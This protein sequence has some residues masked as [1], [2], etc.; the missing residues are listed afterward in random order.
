MC[1]T[2]SGCCKLV[3]CG[4]LMYFRLLDGALVVAGLAVTCAQ[5]QAYTF[6]IDDTAGDA[7]IYWGANAHNPR[8]GDVISG[9]SDGH[10]TAL[11]EIKGLDAALV[12]NDLVFKVYTNYN[13]AS[14]AGT[15]YGDLFMTSGAN[16]SPAP[17]IGVVGAAQ[18]HSVLD[19]LG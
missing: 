16:Y 7:D 5:A 18:G 1:L 15:A 9:R 17:D 12:G 13:P 6:T 10:H 3:G 2:S 11:F 19:R 4:F 14:E 8:F